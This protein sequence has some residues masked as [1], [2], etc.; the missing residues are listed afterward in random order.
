[1]FSVLELST[2]QTIA[3][4]S[5][6]V[7]ATTGARAHLVNAISNDDTLIV[8]QIEGIF[9][10]GEMVTVDG[11]NVETINALHNY[12]YSDTRSFVSRDESTNA[13]EF[14]CDAILEDLEL[15][16]GSTFT[17]STSSG[18]VATVD[19]V[20]A[21]DGARVAGT[22]TVTT[23]TTDGTGT[24]ATFS[25]VING[26]GAATVTILK[27]GFGYVVNETFTVAAA[28]IG[29]AGAALTFDVATVGPSIEGLQSNFALDLRLMI[30]FTSTILSLL[31]LT[32]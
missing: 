27:G 30:K 22:Y 9:A 1:M 20:S 23:Y 18:N 13:V 21:A 28:Q 25:I 19:T 4:G 14:T 26:S 29:G 10:Q 11:E 32:P 31:L 24:G 5:L 3:A 16:E 2:A 8:Y 7:G 17:Y 12:Q 15:V 6:V